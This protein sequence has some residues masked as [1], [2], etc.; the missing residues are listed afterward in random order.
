MEDIGTNINS[1]ILYFYL[2]CPRDTKP[3][4]VL[5]MFCYRI[6]DYPVSKLTKIYIVKGA[7]ILSNMR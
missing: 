3:A 4:L 1:P 6:S 7:Y 2:W 5:S